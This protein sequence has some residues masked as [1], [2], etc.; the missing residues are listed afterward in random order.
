MIDKIVY[1]YVSI[2]ILNFMFNK[3]LKLKNYGKYI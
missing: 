3:C 1:L 2:K